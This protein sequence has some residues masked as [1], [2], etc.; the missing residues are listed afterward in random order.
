MS[1]VT[2]GGGWPR[3]ALLGESK[4]QQTKEEEKTQ[5]NPWYCE[6]A[7]KQMSGAAEGRLG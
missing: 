2:P 7:N 4:K 6:N 1:R 5:E 3:A